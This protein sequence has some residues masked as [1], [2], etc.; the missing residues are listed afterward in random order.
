L[1]R[2]GVSIEKDLLENFDILLSEKNYATRSEAIRDLIRDAL[3]E[4]KINNGETDVLGSLTLIYDHHTTKLLQQMSELQHQHHGLIISVMHLHISHL[5][6][7]E[8]LALSGKAKQITQL[9]NEIM[10]LKGIKH[11]KL[12]ITLP[13]SNI[14]K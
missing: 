2:F 14:A 13:S 7:M 12:F 1:V 5:D 8:V 3:I 11:A 6:C 9:A 4:Y 10:S